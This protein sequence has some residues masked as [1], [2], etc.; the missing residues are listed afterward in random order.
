MQNR[1]RV[2]LINFQ[3][4]GNTS[5]HLHILTS[6]ERSDENRHGTKIIFFENQ[7]CNEQENAGFRSHSHSSR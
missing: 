6:L 5:L 1:Q 7:D 4:T 2:L 3:K